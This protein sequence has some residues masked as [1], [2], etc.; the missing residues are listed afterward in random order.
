MKVKQYQN[1]ILKPSE[2][3]ESEKL[4]PKIRFVH[5]LTEFLCIRSPLKV[6]NMLDRMLSFILSPL[7]VHH[8]SIGRLISYSIAKLI[9]PK[10]KGMIVCPIK[11][12]LQLCF[13]ISNG[14][15]YYMRGYYECTTLFMID[16]LLKPGDTFIDIGASVGQMTVYGSKA[17]GK[18]GKVFA[19]EP[20]PSRYFE[21]K[22]S[23]ALNNCSNV[24]PLNL[25]L[26]SKPGEVDLYLNRVSPTMIKP[27]IKKGNNKPIKSVTVK[28]SR[29]DTI[30][31]KY[32]ISN[33][34]FIKID[35]EGYELE[36][37][38]GTGNLLSS[39]N[40]PVICFEYGVYYK[41]IDVFNFI[42]KKNP[43]YLF[44]YSDYGNE[45]PNPKFIQTDG[46]N[47]K[48]ISEGTNI[49]ALPKKLL[50]LIED[51]MKKR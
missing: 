20:T 49:Y 16:K 2:K 36:V 18:D 23:I 22:N 4:L 10:P 43:N 1:V 37:L 9:L 51:M 14:T 12:G 26:G 17:V 7:H 6:G 13:S 50:Y 45:I 8:L 46:F 44:F 21:L 11:D 29:L 35:V 5:K 48:D 32:N 42:K 3:K 28:I 19:I 15:N 30:I 24:I 40:P 25:G 38:K 39:K 47:I 33:T 27:N 31:K 41:S 34:K